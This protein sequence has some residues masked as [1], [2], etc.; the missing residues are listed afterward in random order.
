[1]KHRTETS[2]GIR[3]A[4]VKPELKSRTRETQHKQQEL[5][6]TNIDTRSLSIPILLL[7]DH[8]YYI[9]VVLVIVVRV[10][11]LTLGIVVAFVKLLV[12]WVLAQLKITQRIEIQLT[13]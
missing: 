13:R 5:N 11:L 1:M 8:N 7:V 4:E 9:F 6:K 12:A 2:V 10:I 3:R